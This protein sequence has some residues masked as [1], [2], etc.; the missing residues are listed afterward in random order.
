MALDASTLEAANASI[1]A[2]VP[3]LRNDRS[4]PSRCRTTRWSL[5]LAAAAEGAQAR[6]AL[7]A[8]YRAYWQPVFWFIAQR[9]GRDAAIEL[10]Q[11]FFVD[12]LVDAGDLRSIERR[13]GQRFRGWL[14]TAL[15]SFLKNEWNYR[16]RKCRDVTK[17]LPWCA[18]EPVDGSNRS[19]QLTAAGH[20]PERQ[21]ERAR[22]LSLL[23]EVLGRLRQEYCSNAAIAGVDGVARFEALKVYLPG[24]NTED[25][26]YGACASALGLSACAVK[27]IVRRLRVRFGELLNEKIRQSVGS[28]ADVGAG[29]RS[30]CRALES[31]PSPHEGA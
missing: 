9:R 28:E 10:T 25:A 20:D 13:P 12:R 8:L 30:L 23:A 16:R 3:W 4:G 6:S 1:E 15:Q 27:Q 5:V 22:A 26:D 29:R 24:P 14:F 21:L 2:R 7:S 18:A 11:A 17:T 19:F 31:P